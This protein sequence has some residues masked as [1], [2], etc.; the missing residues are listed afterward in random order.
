MKKKRKMGFA[1][2]IAQWYFCLQDAAR[3]RQSRRAAGQKAQDPESTVSGSTQT[4]KQH[5]G[6]RKQKDET[7]V[8]AC[9]KRMSQHGNGKNDER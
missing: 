7:L 6:I 9:I 5:S 4:E 1:A 2:A 8:H 3:Q